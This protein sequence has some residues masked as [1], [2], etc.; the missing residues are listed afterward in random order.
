MD[1]V[2]PHSTSLPAQY[3]RSKLPRVIE[4]GERGSFGWVFPFV[5]NK[6][7]SNPIPLVRHLFTYSVACLLI[8]TVPISQRL[9]L[10]SIF[11]FFPTFLTLCPPRGIKSQSQVCT[12]EAGVLWKCGLGLPNTILSMCFVDLL[13]IFLFLPLSSSSARQL[14]KYLRD[15]YLKD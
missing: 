14:Q 2:W 1:S 5:L 3:W 7:P 6:K 15:R 8:K 10:K 12:K 9:P 4:L 11:F 13:E